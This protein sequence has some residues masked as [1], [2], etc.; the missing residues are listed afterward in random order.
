MLK[1]INCKGRTVKRL[2]RARE[3]DAESQVRLRRVS[4]TYRRL[5]IV[6][7]ALMYY[8]NR[9]A[10]EEDKVQERETLKIVERKIEWLKETKRIK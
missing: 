7:H 4:K 10:P 1:V 9:E 2:Q 6:K 3:R 5:Q 8:L